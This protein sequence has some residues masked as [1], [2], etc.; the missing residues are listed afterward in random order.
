MRDNRNRERNDQEIGRLTALIENLSIRV[1]QLEQRERAANRIPRVEAEAVE[2]VPANE[3]NRDFII[4][5]RVEV[6]NS[7]RGQRGLQGTV[8]RVSDEWI[9]FQTES[10]GI[11][12]RKRP[13]L[14]RI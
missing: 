4:G 7:Y 2:A 13:N 12:R 10:L 6:T 14:R 5:D 1:R 11:R 9:H 3:V 8:V